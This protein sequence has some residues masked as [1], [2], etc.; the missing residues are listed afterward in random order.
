MCEGRRDIHDNKIQTG[1]E[2]ITYSRA[3]LGAYIRR[4][5]TFILSI[6]KFDVNRKSEKFGLVTTLYYHFLHD[7]ENAKSLLI[8]AE[9]NIEPG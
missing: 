4:I 3:W 5:V 1:Q 8:K 7:F 9:D 2:K 6:S